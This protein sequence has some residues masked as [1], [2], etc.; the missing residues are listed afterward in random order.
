MLCEQLVLGV[1]S[2][3]EVLITKGPPIFNVEERLAIASSCKW[4]DE[5]VPDVPYI[6]TIS[7]IDSLNCS[8]VAHGDDLA[9]G[10]DGKCCYSELR[11]VDRLLVVK[12]TEG[13][14][15]TDILKRLLNISN[16]V[17]QPDEAKLNII[18]K[19]NQNKLYNSS[20]RLR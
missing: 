10:A 11:K 17:E 12:R 19:V 4:V 8:H 14:S 20:K 9:L 7:F 6:P 5:V 2:D 15:T 1:V 13:I 18:D 16:D 3:H